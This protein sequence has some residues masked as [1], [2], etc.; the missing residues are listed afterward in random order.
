MKKTALAALCLILSLCA[1]ALTACDSASDRINEDSEILSV[2]VTAADG[3]TFELDDA[4]TEFV[5]S[6]LLRTSE[7]E[8]DPKTSIIGWEFAYDYKIRFT[9]LKRKF[10]FKKEEQTL[11][12]AFGTTKS[13]T[14]ALGEQISGHYET[15]WTSFSPLTGSRSIANSGSEDA[16]A[17]HEFLEGIIVSERQRKYDD[18]MAQFV[19]EGFAVNDLSGNDLLAIFIG[20]EWVSVE[21]QQG[22]E[23]VRESTG[24]SYRVFYTTVERAKKVYGFFHGINCRKNDAF[25]GYGDTMPPDSIL[26]RVFASPES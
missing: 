7:F 19:D 4:Q 11:S 9:V 17:L 5:T 10:L 3:F 6:V 25:V 20:E 16:A 24:E 14:N 2:S 8:S 26:E 23:A 21:A 15:E 18:I 22:F 12:Y 1:L 13:R